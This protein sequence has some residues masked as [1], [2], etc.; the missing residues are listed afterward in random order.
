LRCPARY[1][2]LL[3]GVVLLLVCAT[4][5]RTARPR[6]SRFTPNPGAARYWTHRF[7]GHGWQAQL[8]LCVAYTESRYELGVSN[9]SSYGPWEINV[10]AWPWANPWKLTH[11]WRYSAKAAW[12][13]SAHGT[14]FHPWTPD[15][16]IS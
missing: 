1:F 10:A 7:F 11:S 12:R 2:T 6:H 8:M 14:N 13:V 4:P 9:G 15:C 3:L 5:G 16:G